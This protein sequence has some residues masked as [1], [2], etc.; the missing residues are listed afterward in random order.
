MFTS[1][2]AAVRFSI[3]YRSKLYHWKFLNFLENF[4]DSSLI[5]NSGLINRLFYGSVFQNLIE[6]ELK[7]NCDQD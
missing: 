4:P 1:E 5:I 7:E 3:V 6:N 2:F